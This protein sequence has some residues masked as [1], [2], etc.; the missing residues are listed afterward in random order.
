MPWG[1][2]NEVQLKRLNK[3]MNPWSYTNDWQEN[4]NEPTLRIQCFLE[5]TSY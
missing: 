1:W 2:P 4:L 5:R 3:Q